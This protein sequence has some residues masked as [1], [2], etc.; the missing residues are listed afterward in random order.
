MLMSSRAWKSPKCFET[1]SIETVLPFTA[2]NSLKNKMVTL[3][4]LL[5]GRLVNRFAEKKL[6]KNNPYIIRDKMI[7]MAVEPNML[8]MGFLNS[9]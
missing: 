8:I 7:K 2:Y 5:I 9:L 6:K 4:L 1:W 3:F